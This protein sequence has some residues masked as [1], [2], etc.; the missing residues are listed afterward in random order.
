MLALTQE[1]GYL[2]LSL[3]TMP[4]L[5]NGPQEGKPHA[6]LSIN[7]TEAHTVLPSVHNLFIV[8]HPGLN[9]TL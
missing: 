9:L 3:R 8:C 7:K 4:V 5:R 2:L 1:E 6:A